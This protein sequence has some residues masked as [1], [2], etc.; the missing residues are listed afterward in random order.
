LHALPHLAVSPSSGSSP[1]Y[2]TTLT[3]WDSLHGSGYDD[4]AAVDGI[5]GLQAYD[6]AKIY[7]PFLFALINVILVIWLVRRDDD[8][9]QA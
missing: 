2:D 9:S 1:G 3:N 8:A 6:P 7:G 5:I 4:R